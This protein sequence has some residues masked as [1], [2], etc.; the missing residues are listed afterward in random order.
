MHRVSF[1]LKISQITTFKM[2]LAIPWS[3]HSCIKAWIQCWSLV[4]SQIN[5]VY[6]K[7]LQCMPCKYY[8]LIINTFTWTQIMWMF[9]DRFFFKCWSSNLLTTNP[10]LVR[11][12]QA[13]ISDCCPITGLLFKSW[14]NFT[15]K[16]HVKQDFNICSLQTSNTVHM[17]DKQFLNLLAYA[18]TRIWLPSSSLWITAQP[19]LWLML[20]YPQSHHT[21]CPTPAT[22]PLHPLP[23][24]LL[25]V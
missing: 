24:S 16:L 4:E 23:R 8:T 7:P 5:N 14:N 15:V 22:E 21:G 17:Q 13:G 19:A 12:E 3:L 11:C 18:L 6:Q 1:L 10:V 20:F 25:T 9:I 2:A